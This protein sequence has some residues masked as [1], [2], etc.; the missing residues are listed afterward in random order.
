MSVW[1]SEWWL[2][3]AIVVVSVGGLGYAIWQVLRRAPYLTDQPKGRISAGPDG[4]SIRTPDGRHMGLPWSDVERVSIRTTDRGPME[5]DVWWHFEVT[6]TRGA[7]SV[8]NDTE[9]IDAFIADA[10]TWLPGFDDEA[11][12]EAMGSTGN[13]EFVVWRR[14][15]TGPG[16]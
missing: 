8:P 15:E 14:S 9:G 10:P 7:L 2:Q 12:I 3:I 4:L 6:E 13:Q 11:I 5:Q 1:L 16:G